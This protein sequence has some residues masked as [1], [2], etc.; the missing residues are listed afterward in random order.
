MTEKFWKYTER[1][2][3]ALLGGTRVPVSGRQR[4]DAPDVDHPT[5]SVEVKSRKTIPRWITTALSQAEASAQEGQVP[6]AILHARGQRFDD[7]LVLVRLKH[8]GAA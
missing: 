5:L 2:I 1:R 3:A 6:V 4:G 8:L 7:A